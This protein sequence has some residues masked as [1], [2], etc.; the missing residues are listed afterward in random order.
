METMKASAKLR[1]LCRLQAE[2]CKTFGNPLRLLILECIADKE[3]SFQELLDLT[4]A[5]KATLSQHTGAMR[6][7]G[8]LVVRRTQR[9]LV[10]AIANPK[11]L[12]AFRLMREA[13][14]D[15][16]AKEKKLAE[17]EPG[18]TSSRSPG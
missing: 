4:G 5:S 13:L 6:R 17:Q 15:R 11:I 12:Q 16:I 7:H 2:C 10:F 1:E 3:R 18:R 8:T 14:L 9:H